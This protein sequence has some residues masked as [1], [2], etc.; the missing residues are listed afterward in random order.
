[1]VGRHNTNSKSTSE[2]RIL[3]TTALGVLMENKAQVDMAN[4]K[5][6]RIQISET[7]KAWLRAGGVFP[8]IL[9]IK[10]ANGSPMQF[11]VLDRLP[12][13]RVP[14]VSRRMGHK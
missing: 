7:T 5:Q 1:M 12:D 9:S 6:R 13:G 14:D 11:E 10:L 8:P 2:L 4:L 3:V